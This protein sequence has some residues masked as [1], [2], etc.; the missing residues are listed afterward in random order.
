MTDIEKHDLVKKYLNDPER[1]DIIDK[2]Q[3][4]DPTK[5]L[6][7]PKQLLKS[8]AGTVIGYWKGD[9]DYYENGKRAGYYPPVFLPPLEPGQ[10]WKF[11]LVSGKFYIA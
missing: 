4:A 1:Q 2:P 5:P 11:D 8:A 9:M 6:W 10:V 7:L 3:Q